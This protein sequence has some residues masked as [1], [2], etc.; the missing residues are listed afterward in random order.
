MEFAFGNR[1]AAL[2]ELN[3]ALQLSPRLAAA[4]ALQGFVQLDAGDTRAALSSFNRARELDAALG[5]A[6]LGRGLCL[7][8]ER[9]FAAAR[10][11]FQ[12]AAALEPQ[13]SLFRTYLGKAASE[14]G[15][16]KAAEK[17]FRL[18]KE[19]DAND[20]TAWL[21]SALHLWSENKLNAAI[22]D[23]E[24]AYDKNDNRAAFRSRELLDGDKSVRSA[25]LAVIYDDAGLTEVSRRAAAR[26]LSES[27]ANFSGHLFLANSLQAQQ[28]ANRFDLRLETAKQSELLV[29]N[30]LA[31]PGA[32][33]LSQVLSQ[34]DRLRFFDQQPVGVSSLT[35]YGSRGDWSETDRKSTV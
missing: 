30:L 9:N 1:R 12:A 2:A 27:Y 7:L 6:W 14:L 16:A 32:G 4:H 10:A 34:S 26:S 15:D 35:S 17:E 31:P 18:A 19:L 29:A 28:D 21:Y 23:L 33:N 25:N 13:R 24:R 20:P 11:A 8:R 22:R 3:R 5:S